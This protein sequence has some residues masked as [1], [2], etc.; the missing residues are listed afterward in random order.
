MNAVEA[1]AK[2]PVPGCTV[3]VWGPTNT[4]NACRAHGGNR[5]NFPEVN[6]DEWGEPNHI[7]AAAGGPPPPAGGPPT[8]EA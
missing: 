2:C 3:S 6:D 7:Q 5:L 8:P 1:F 4:E